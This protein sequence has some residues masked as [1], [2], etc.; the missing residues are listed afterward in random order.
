MNPS[1]LG[2]FDKYDE[3]S[4]NDKTFYQWSNDNNVYTE[5]SAPGFEEMNDGYVI[6]FVGENPP[7]DNYLI[8]AEGEYVGSPRNIAYIKISHNQQDV[9]SEGETQFGGYY[10][11]NGQ[12]MPE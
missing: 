3:I 10:S 12:W 11:F 5:L 4:S 2:P 1:G 9:L 8:P 7:L 6:F